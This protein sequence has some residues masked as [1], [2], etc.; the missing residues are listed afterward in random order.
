MRK[1]ALRNRRKSLHRAVF[2]LGRLFMPWIFTLWKKA[3][4]CSTWRKLTAQSCET[5]F[6]FAFFF[7]S[8][9]SQHDPAALEG[10]HPQGAHEVAPRWPPGQLPCSVLSPQDQPYWMQQPWWGT[11]KANA[12]M[13][14]P[15]CGVLWGRC[16]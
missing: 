2:S 6:C 5:W 15:Q 14:V 12:T 8:Q 4:S 13:A 11:G 16:P 9:G 1:S 10:A 3:V 7:I